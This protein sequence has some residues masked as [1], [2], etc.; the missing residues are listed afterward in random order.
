MHVIHPL[1][2]DIMHKKLQHLRYLTLDSFGLHFSLMR[3]VI[4][5][6]VQNVRN[7]SI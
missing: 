4:E 6:L 1:A 2:V 5:N 3:I 7:L